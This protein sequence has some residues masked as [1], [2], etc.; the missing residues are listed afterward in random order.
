MGL[1]KDL[2]IYLMMSTVFGTLLL[3]FLG[4]LVKFS[5]AGQWRSPMFLCVFASTL[6]ALTQMIDQ[7]VL[8]VTLR[9]YIYTARLTR[10]A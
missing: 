8:E 7:I 5:S 4:V 6:L 9:H 2:D 1:S 10:W 3:P